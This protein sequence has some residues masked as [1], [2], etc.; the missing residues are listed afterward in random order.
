MRI[1]PFKSRRTAPS[2]DETATLKKSAHMF[3][4][5]GSPVGGA[6]ADLQALRASGALTDAEYADEVSATLAGRRT[7]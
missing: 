5:T 2:A 4:M 7:A 3:A 6:I 1:G